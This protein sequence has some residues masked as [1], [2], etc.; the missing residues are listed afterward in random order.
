MNYDVFISYCRRN[1]PLKDWVASRLSYCGVRF[2]CDP[3]LRA[4]NWRDQLRTRLKQSRVMLI[5]WTQDYSQ[6]DFCRKEYEWAY[7]QEKLIIPLWFENCDIPPD[8]T[9]LHDYQRVNFYDGNDTLNNRRF[10]E[11]LRKEELFDDMYLEH[12][13]Q[14]NL[15]PIPPVRAAAGGDLDTAEEESPEAESAGEVPPAARGVELPRIQELLQ[16]DPAAGVAPF[17]SV[18]GDPDADVRI[19][20][21]TFAGD[22]LDPEVVAVLE[23][24]WG[25]AARLSAAA[26]G[27]R[28]DFERLRRLIVSSLLD[29]A[30]TPANP[31]PSATLA[32]MG[33][34][35]LRH[36]PELL[37]GSAVSEDRVVVWNETVQSVLTRT[38]TKA[39]RNN[40]SFRMLGLSFGDFVEAEDRAAACLQSAGGVA[41]AVGAHRLASAAFGYGF[42]QRFGAAARLTEQAAERIAAL[43]EALPWFSPLFSAAYRLDSGQTTVL[44]E[45]RPAAVD[46]PEDPWHA[47]AVELL[48]R[49]ALEEVRRGLTVGGIAEDPERGRRG[50]ECLSRLARDDAHALT[51]VAQRLGDVLQDVAAGAEA[52]GLTP[53]EAQKLRITYCEAERAFGR[54]LGSAYA[55]LESALLRHKARFAFGDGRLRE[56]L[57]IVESADAEG[58]TLSAGDLYVLVAANIRLHQQGVLGRLDAARAAVARLERDFPDAEMLAEVQ[59]QVQWYDQKKDLEAQYAAMTGLRRGADVEA[60][61]TTPVGDDPAQELEGARQRMS[62]DMQL[63]SARAECLARPNDL[64]AVARLRGAVVSEAERLLEQDG[65]AAVAQLLNGVQAEFPGHRYLSQLPQEVL[66]QLVSRVS[67]EQLQQL[68]ALTSKGPAAPVRSP[69]PLPPEQERSAGPEVTADELRRGVPRS[70]QRIKDYMDRYHPETET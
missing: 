38:C 6:S 11:L 57:K 56:A 26:L 53:W 17:F 35:A 51:T 47:T 44:V 68:R 28:L 36:S 33:M 25:D 18:M 20:A 54:T 64:S 40:D 66:L 2:W 10:E 65:V 52:P 45:D 46:R 34:T 43:P 24:R 63:E 9:Q 48:S 3:G 8:F 62:R 67:A 37:S 60:A 1:T 13:E 5:V 29:V 19:A 23:G 42:A 55:R 32:V 50:L 61:R 30:L 4:G 69:R 70:V 39:L 59:E 41:V 22:E 14:T 58:Q 7:G 27:R 31:L 12:A 16:I 49:A 15:R 21:G